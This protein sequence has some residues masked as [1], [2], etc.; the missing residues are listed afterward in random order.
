LQSL[1]NLFFVL[2]AVG[3]HKIGYLALC[4]TAENITGGMAGTALVTYLSSLC[5]P[6]FTATQYALLGSLAS[7]G[8]TVVASSGGV[9][10][11]KI[12]WVRFFLLTSVIGLPVLLLFLWT[13]PPDDFRN[14]Q[15]KPALESTD[16]RLEDPT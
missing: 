7:L 15:L 11:E 16:G 2:Q 8:R 10:S 12:G 3:G 13:G 9:L 1:G 4:V 6:A 5:S 14:N